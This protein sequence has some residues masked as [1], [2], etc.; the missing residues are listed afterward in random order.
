MGSF[1]FVKPASQMKIVN[2][3][4]KKGT[5]EFQFSIN[6]DL[7]NLPLGDDYIR[8]IKNYSI[9]ENFNLKSIEKI[10][11]ANRYSHRLT[12][13]TTDLKQISNL[14]V[15]IKYSIPEWVKNTG[16]DIDD[17]PMDSKQQKQ[18]FGF[19]YLM[20]GVS[21]AYIANNDSLQFKIPITIN[22]NSPKNGLPWVLFFA[23]S[24]FLAVFIYI[25]NKK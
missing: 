8:D 18:T 4:T 9:N 6:A 14:I 5:S 10:D 22:K 24:I 16:S 23:I 12:F 3:E 20:M 25:K 7:K 11:N 15:G 21:E 17:D 13:Y 19:K 1:E 2:A